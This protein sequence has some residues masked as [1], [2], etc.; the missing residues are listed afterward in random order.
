[1]EKA[2]EFAVAEVFSIKK[3]CG[4]KNSMAL[5]TVEQL[6]DHDDAYSEAQSV[7]NEWMNQKLRLE[8]EMDDDGE[9][10]EIEEAKQLFKTT[11]SSYNNFD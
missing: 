9:E 6:Q 4:G 11:Q 5:Q 10:E 1:V 7:L 8:L 2:S 3:P